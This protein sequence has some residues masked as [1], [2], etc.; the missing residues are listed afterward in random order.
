MMSVSLT[1]SDYHTSVLYPTAISSAFAYQGLYVTQPI[2]ANAK[3]YWV[4][5]SGSQNILMSG[6]VRAIDSVDVVQGWNMIGSLSSAVSVSSISTIPG[7][8]VTSPIFGYDGAYQN[9]TTVDPGHGYWVKVSRSGKLYLSSSGEPPIGVPITMIEQRS[10]APPPPPEQADG[11]Q[12]ASFPAEIALE[13]N[14]PNP[15][16]PATVIRY[17]LPARVEPTL[18]PPISMAEDPPI[19]KAGLSVYPVSLRV[20]NMLGQAVATLVDG[21]QAPG[22]K[23]VSWN[24]GELPSGLYYYRLTVGAYNEVKKMMLVK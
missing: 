6:D 18:N 3:G 24:A 2:L 15:F 10:E 4:K 7:G 16:N 14:Y 12:S 11:P 9:A 5:F 8:I 22:Y 13:Q 21:I 20:Y 23:A 17:S 19:S 1:V